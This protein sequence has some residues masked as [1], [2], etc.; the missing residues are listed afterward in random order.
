[1]S[2][3]KGGESSPSQSLSEWELYP[4]ITLLDSYRSSEEKVQEDLTLSPWQKTECVPF[5][6]CQEE[7]RLA[8][9]TQNGAS[10]EH[11]LSRGSYAPDTCTFIITIVTCVTIVAC[12]KNTCSVQL[13]II[14]T[15]SEKIDRRNSK[16]WL[17][18]CSNRRVVIKPK[19]NGTKN[20]KFWPHASSTCP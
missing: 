9:V 2:H 20:A 8:N 17:W 10:K 13:I 1:M 15:S 14:R 7:Q 19:R 6:N 16:F 18:W 4:R 5:V 11:R 3:P 12:V